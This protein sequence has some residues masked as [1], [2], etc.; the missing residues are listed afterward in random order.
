M[1]GGVNFRGSFLLIITP[2]LAAAH[3]GADIVWY[4]YKKKNEEEKKKKKRKSNHHLIR[5]H[6]LECFSR[7]FCLLQSFRDSRWT[8]KR[9]CLHRRQL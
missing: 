1:A 7:S 6:F 4:S 9:Q 5:T 2:R 3:I 8:A